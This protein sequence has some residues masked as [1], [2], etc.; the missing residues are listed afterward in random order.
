MLDGIARNG[1]SLNRSLELGAQWG[2]VVSA[3]PRG[4][5]CRG[6]WAID[7][8]MGLPPFGACVRGF[9]MVLLSVGGV[10]QL[11]VGVTGFWKIASFIPVAGSSLT[12]VPFSLLLTC[13]RIV[14]PGGSGFLS[15]PDL[16]DEQFRK[17]CCFCR[18]DTGVADPLFSMQKS[19]AGCGHFPRC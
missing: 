13:D 11:A 4:P 5:L 2:S 10:N 3:G 12:L 18:A 1:K 6:D 19:V 9:C 8:D 7:L 15:D 17:A 16:I 14:T